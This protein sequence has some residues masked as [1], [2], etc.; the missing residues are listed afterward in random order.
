MLYFKMAEQIEELASKT[1]G[2]NNYSFI[3]AVVGATYP[4]E[5][6]KIRKILA[7]SIF[8]VP[9]FGVQGEKAEDLG[10]FF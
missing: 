8:L 3:G 5:A 10:V 6:R 1:V 9:G 4:E 7:H 2:I